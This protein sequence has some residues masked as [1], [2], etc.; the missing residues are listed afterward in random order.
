MFIRHFHTQSFCSILRNKIFTNN[1]IPRFHIHTWSNYRDRRSYILKAVWFSDDLNK[2]FV[3]YVMKTLQKVA[4]SPTF[5]ID[6]VYC[7]EKMLT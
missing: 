2:N 6:H 4:E 3:L 5:C 7:Q 1:K